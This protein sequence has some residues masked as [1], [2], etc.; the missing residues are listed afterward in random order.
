[1]TA[2]AASERPSQHLQLELLHTSGKGT[3]AVA[4]WQKPSS[5]SSTSSA[6]A[7][8]CGCCCKRPAGDTGAFAL[9]LL[10]ELLA[11]EVAALLL[12]LSETPEEEL[13][14]LCAAAVF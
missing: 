4:T 7:A 12:L 14:L 11:V 10:P 6:H 2:A 8:C 3:A 5:A 1:L 13:L 9:P